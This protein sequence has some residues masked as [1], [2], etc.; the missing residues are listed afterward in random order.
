MPASGRSPPPGSS[1]RSGSSRS[2]IA[3]VRHEVGRGRCRGSSGLGWKCRQRTVTARN[4]CM[5]NVGGADQEGQHATTATRGHH[6][7]A[8]R[9]SRPAWLLERTASRSDRRELRGLSQPAVICSS[10]AWV[11]PS[12]HLACD[13]EERQN[14]RQPR[15]PGSGRG[16]YARNS[17]CRNLGM[18][19]R[20]RGRG[21]KLVSLD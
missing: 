1:V 21:G 3:A 5:P 20:T 16:L 2:R 13:V 15:S 10:M 17:C 4:A 14:R 18:R 9:A 8:A 12:G 7:H 6:R 11:S 19:L